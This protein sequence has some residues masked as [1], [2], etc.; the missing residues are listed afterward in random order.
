MDV[1]GAWQLV[2]SALPTGGFCHSYGLEAAIKTKHIDA[3]QTPDFIVMSIEQNAS[4]YLPIIKA[5]MQDPT[6]QTWYRM[7]ELCG[8]LISNQVAS[9]ASISQVNYIHVYEE[10]NR[11]CS[12][13]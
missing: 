3:A 5:T 9:R 8:A 6:L 12:D 2:D 7:D 4:L 1:F 10:L 13:I 11:F